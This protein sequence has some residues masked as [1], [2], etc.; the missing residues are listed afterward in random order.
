MNKNYNLND[1]TVIFPLFKT[2]HKLIN[3]F[4]Q[5]RSLKLVIL[6][7]SNDQA[8][9]NKILKILFLQMKA[10]YYKRYLQAD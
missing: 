4:E 6:D 9:K 10:Q 8:L 7:Q 5:Y 2:P 3:R 1:I